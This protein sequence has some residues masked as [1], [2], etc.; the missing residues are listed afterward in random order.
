M[1][2]ST[3]VNFAKEN[4]RVDLVMFL[5]DHGLG[6]KP[7]NEATISSLHTLISY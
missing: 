1:G 6:T 2:G 4:R 3:V 5:W 7:G